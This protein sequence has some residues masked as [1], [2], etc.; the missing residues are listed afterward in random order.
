MK[1]VFLGTNGWYT[2]P[3][4]NTACVL[5]D[6]EEGYIIFD[7]GNG[8][9][10]IDE[11][12]KED[13]PISL[14]ISH[15][16]LDHVNGLHILNKFAF[17]QGIDVYVGEGR[18][19]DFTTLVHPPY[20]I[21][22]DPEGEYHLPTEIRLH[23]LSEGIHKTPF[24]I[25]CKK[26]YHAYE[27]HGFRIELE[28]KTVAYSGDTGIGENS[29]TLFKDVDML[30]HECAGKDEEK[31]SWGHTGPLETAKLAKDVGTKQLILT[32]FDAT[33]PTSRKKAEKKAKEIFPH[34]LA[35]K[36][37]MIVTL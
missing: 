17:S 19:R 30:I 26:L 29:Y 2:T 33:D 10:Q 35:A 16:H 32:H 22:I 37:G 25:L 11:Y 8:F 13:K 12:I 24:P 6:A 9:Y 5:I 23:E 31:S 1:I 34:T 18:S 14:F 15:F 21:G 36:D 20:T 7:A 28:G 4:G 27:D 3:S